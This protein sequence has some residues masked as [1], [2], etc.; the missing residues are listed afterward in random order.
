VFK[1]TERLSAGT[2]VTGIYT[3]SDV[4]TDSTGTLMDL[5]FG[6]TMQ[7]A[8]GNQRHRAFVSALV[9]IPS[10]FDNTTGWVRNV[11]ANFTITGTALFATG[12]NVPVFTGFIP[13]TIGTTYLGQTR[14]INL[15]VAKGFTAP[16]E[17]KIEVRGEAYNIANHPQFTGMPPSVLGNGEGFGIIPAFVGTPRAFLSSNPRTIQLALRVIF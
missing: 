3:Y 12:A 14:N 4:R 15:A 8:F 7:E 13:I 2:Q 16:D 5:T 10:L 9:D 17:V 6:R 1:L 11:L